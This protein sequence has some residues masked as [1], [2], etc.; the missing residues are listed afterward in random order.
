MSVRTALPTVLAT[1]LIGSS[2]VLPTTAVAASP[3]TGHQSSGGYAARTTSM[4]AKPAGAHATD[5]TVTNIKN[6][7]CFSPGPLRICIS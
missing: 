2:A 1:L 3:D 7:N 4:H 6:T 5:V